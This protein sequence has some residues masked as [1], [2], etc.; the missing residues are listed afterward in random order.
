MNT[1]PSPNANEE[2]ITEGE[3][4]V[5]S[6]TSVS[7]ETNATEVLSTNEA[8]TQA[9]LPTDSTSYQSLPIEALKLDRFQGGIVI[10]VVLVGCL[11][12][13]I[14]PMFFASATLDVWAWAVAG[15]L[16]LLALVVYAAWFYPKAAHRCASW[17][18]SE[19]GLEIR[20]GVWWRHRIV[21]PHSRMQHSDIEQGPLQRM[22]SLATLVIHTAGTK[23]SS[24]QLENLK[25]ET[26]EQLRDALT[27]G[28]WAMHT[29]PESPVTP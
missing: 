29:P 8:A 24:V 13:L 3:P 22:Y 19:H 15:C 27:G 25:S 9:P 23:N 2:T 21:I 10:A 16:L 26:A 17:R 12:G 28:R 14:V 20:R 11:V 6:E 4:V 1:E 18:I 5:L 7:T